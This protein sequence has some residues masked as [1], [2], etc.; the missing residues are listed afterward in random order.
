MAK[1]RKNGNYVTENRAR[2]IE[3]KLAQKRKRKIKAYVKT[4]VIAAVAV[5]LIAAVIV[6]ICALAGAFKYRPKATSHVTVTLSNGETLHIELYGNDAPKTVEK[7][8]SDVGTGFYK[9]AE[10]H[11]LV[12]GLLYG[13]QMNS[14]V[15][16]GGI[17][18]EFEANGFKNKIKHERG[19]I[20]MARNA[21]SYNSAFGQFFIVT[22]KSPEL[23]GNY[24][25]FGKIIDG[26]DIIDAAIKNA[27][28]SK[29]GIITAQ[30]RLTITNITVHD[31][32]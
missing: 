27:E 3:E 6:G 31:A 15:L 10:L 21:D 5:L 7:F 32:H 29:E 13:G 23:D 8:L 26:M 28:V 14:G 11:T 4:A 17:T 18:G 1:K 12:N 16:T 22:D 19:V 24:A 20:S 25:A 9:N 2:K 30:Y